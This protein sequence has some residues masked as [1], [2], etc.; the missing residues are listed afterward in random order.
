MELSKK[1]KKELAT[2]LYADGH[3]TGEASYL[4]EQILGATSII[5]P[6]GGGADGKV[7]LNVTDFA[8]VTS[9]GDHGFYFWADRYPIP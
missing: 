3:K 9:N 7:W 6:T 2:A 5:R 8:T 4:G 1:G